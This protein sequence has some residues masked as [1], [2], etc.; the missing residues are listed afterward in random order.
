M[1]SGN[2]KQRFRI[3]AECVFV[4]RGF[5]DSPKHSQSICWYKF[6]RPQSEVKVVYFDFLLITSQIQRV[7]SGYIKQSTYVVADFFLVSRG[8]PD[9]PKDSQ[10]MFYN[11]QVTFANVKRNLLFAAAW[12]VWVGASPT[13][14]KT[15][16]LYTHRIFQLPTP[17][18]KIVYFVFFPGIVQC[19]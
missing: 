13:H 12:L 18:V 17:Q 14:Q 16:D 4:S 19:W 1:T 7:M 10:N 6:K 2:F 15:A 8:F 3:A 11:L 5:L 9:S